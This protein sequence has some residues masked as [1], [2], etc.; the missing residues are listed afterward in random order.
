MLPAARLSD[1]DVHQDPS[2]CRPFGKAT[3]D[4]QSLRAEWIGRLIAVVIIRGI[5]HI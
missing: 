1:W 3:C 4:M 2:S 5:D